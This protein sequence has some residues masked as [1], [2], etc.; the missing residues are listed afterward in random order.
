MLY[1]DAYDGFLRERHSYAASSYTKAFVRSYAVRNVLRGHSGCVNSIEFSNDGSVLLTGSD[2]RRICIF[3][4]EDGPLGFGL[5]AKVPLRH[6]ANIFH[7]LFLP[8]NPAVVLSCALDGMTVVTDIVD[9]GYSSVIASR[10]AL[11]SKIACHPAWAHTAFV[12]YGDGDVVWVD[13]RLPSSHGCSPSVVGTWNPHQGCVE[14]VNALAVHQS[15]PYLLC[16]GTNTHLAYFMDVRRIDVSLNSTA[17]ARRRSALGVVKVASRNSNEGIGGLSFSSCGSR[18]L[19][20]HKCNDVFSVK[21][22]DALAAEETGHDVAAVQCTGR[23]NAKTMFKEAIYFCDDQ[24]IVSG[25]D[26]GYLYFWDSETGEQLHRTQGDGDIVNCVLAHESRPFLLCSGIDHTTKV[27]YSNGNLA[28]PASPCSRE[29]FGDRVIGRSA[30]RSDSDN[31]S[32]ETEAPSRG[33]EGDLFEDDDRDVESRLEAMEN[34]HFVLWLP[35]DDD[36]DAH[37]SAS[38]QADYQNLRVLFGAFSRQAR[39]LSNA[40]ANVDEVFSL[41][42]LKQMVT[43][44]ELVRHH[45]GDVWEP[46][47]LDEGADSSS[48][49]SNE[50]SSDEMGSEVS[51]DECNQE[52]TEEEDEE[53]GAEGESSGADSV[54]DESSE[55]RVD[56]MF[57]VMCLRLVH[58]FICVCDQLISATFSDDGAPVLS[59]HWFKAGYGGLAWG[60]E[61][62]PLSAAR[63]RMLLVVCEELILDKGALFLRHHATAGTWK[64]RVCQILLRRIYFEMSSDHCEQSLALIEHVLTSKRY[65]QLSGLGPL[66][67][68]RTSHADDDSRRNRVRLVPLALKVKVLRCQPEENTRRVAEAISAL[69]LALQQVKANSRIA[70]RAYRL[71]SE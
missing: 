31:D 51:M 12:G 58:Q 32:T 54:G 36:D 27:L 64:K 17:T 6:E 14:E 40:D 55:P 20:N 10:N 43:I 23:R 56:V 42:V 65:E 71:L 5:R 35:V 16:L 9:G 69:Q 22:R 24:F 3:G 67:S 59:R 63:L 2:D 45:G 37:R 18:L 8:N 44:C 50:S 15:S 28:H 66:P 62:V 41:H 29:N 53:N 34:E 30:F 47:P 26:C 39:L 70:R 4:V 38:L 48:P 57:L 61:A 21:W 11:A 60:C 46:Q 52:E 13:L 7:A 33:S 25:G 19:I 1:C 68:R 49:S